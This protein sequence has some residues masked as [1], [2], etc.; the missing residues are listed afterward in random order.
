[1]SQTRQ[2]LA[3]HVERLAKGPAFQDWN[4]MMKA[5]Q[6]YVAERKDDLVSAPP[7]KLQFSQGHAQGCVA[8]L[9][10]FDEATKATSRN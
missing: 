1:M 5:L 9:K 6:A 8:L 4:N 7:E 2:E 10:I 3:K